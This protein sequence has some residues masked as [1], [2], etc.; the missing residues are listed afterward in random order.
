LL[1]TA[2]ATSSGSHNTTAAASKTPSSRH[3]PG[4]ALKKTASWC[5]GSGVRTTVAQEVAKG[6]A[7]VAAALQQLLLHS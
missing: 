1:I 4:D 6:T 7:T 5:C 2:R 3:L